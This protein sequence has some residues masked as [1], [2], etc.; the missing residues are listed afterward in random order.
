MKLQTKKKKET[1]IHERQTSNPFFST[2]SQ[3][4]T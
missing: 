3:D 4:L 1:K 2:Q